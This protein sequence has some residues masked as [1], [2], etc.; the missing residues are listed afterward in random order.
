MV[1]KECIHEDDVCSN[2]TYDGTEPFRSGG[3][4]P[5]SVY[6]GYCLVVCLTVMF[7]TWFL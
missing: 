5:V 4:V 3:S 6:C 7:A 2:G 1:Q